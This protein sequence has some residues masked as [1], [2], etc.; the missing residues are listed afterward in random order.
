[1]KKVLP[2][3]IDR[4]SRIK[5]PHQVA[6]GLRSG[7][8]AGYWK[9][10]ERLPS[11][12][13]MKRLLGVSIRA[14]IEALRILAA[15]GLVTLREKSGAV[16]NLSRVL[17]KKGS[18][19]LVVPDGVQ[20]YLVSRLF[21]CI[22]QQLNAAHYLAIT[23]SVFHLTPNGKYDVT[24]LRVELRQ[25]FSMVITLADQPEI[26]REIAASGH[27]FLVVGGRAMPTVNCVGGMPYAIDGAIDGFIAACLR[28]GLKRVMVVSKWRN[29]MN[30]MRRFRANGLAAEEW[31]LSITTKA[32]RAEALWNGSFRAFDRRFR[33]E[34]VQWL[35]DVLFFTDDHC[36][37]GASLALALRHVDVPGQV[38]L[39]VFTGRGRVPPFPC[40]VARV[41]QDP[42]EFSKIVA[43]AVLDFLEH[44]RR[45]GGTE[46]AFRF[47][48]G[49]TL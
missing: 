43:K 33:R 7:I 48:E 3:S 47:V 6:D 12:R 45:S 21:E 19:L 23:T 29:D 46:L 11:S 49:E 37:I 22:R 35:P 28:K 42:V 17:F 25:S 44:G 14:P 24:Q 36:F 9:N 30:L 40:A 2:F 10:G 20:A 41:E 32:D 8:L 4:S 39:A 31:V 26:N 34:G 1:M 13:Q 5:Y 16:V 18:V 38:R 27:P 15:E